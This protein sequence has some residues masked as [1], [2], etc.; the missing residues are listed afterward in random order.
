[1][2]IYKIGCGQIMQVRLFGNEEL[3]PPRC[4]PARQTTEYVM[5]VL[6]KGELHIQNNNQ[7]ITM[8]P[9]DIRI[10]QKGDYQK[11]L[12]TTYCTYFYIHFDTAQIH[13]CSF[14][15]EEFD[16]YWTDRKIRFLQSN[17]FD[18]SSYQYSE[19]LL[20]DSFH[21][22]APL[23]AYLEREL[24]KHK[25][26]YKEIN[27]KASLSWALMS[28]LDE[29]SREYFDNTVCKN[30]LLGQCNH[31]IVQELIR[32][33]DV[34][35]SEKITGQDLEQRFHFSF[36]HANRLFKKATGNTIFAYK[37]TQRIDRAKVLL[38][39]TDNTVSQIAAE[40]GYTDV[41]SF[42]HAFKK[43]TGFSPNEYAK[44][45]IRNSEL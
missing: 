1:M 24:F 23:L 2:E 20:P 19:I 14:T 32:Y 8:H 30:V 18:T 36:D 45:Y 37:N 43:A 25:I 28:I 35:F 5:Y 4:H 21:I 29:L 41:F 12:K 15:E 13:R 10:F 11:P 3:I 6:F 40:V 22:N 44:S 33:L 7:D 27:Y 34:N 26:R 42:S 17:A 16:Q 9:G 31:N 39:T 38:T